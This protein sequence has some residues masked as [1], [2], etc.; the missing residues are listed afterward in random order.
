MS[1]Y[2][3]KKSVSSEGREA[4]PGPSHSVAGK[5][6]LVEGIEA[7]PVQR[8]ATGEP[9]KAAEP[10]ADT[11]TVHTAVAQAP[12]IAA[13]TAGIDK[14]GFIDNSDGAKIRTGPVEAGGKTVRDQPLPP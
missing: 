14:P 2:D 5:H 9:A 12:E 11:A 10:A 4:K 1:F 8:R 3:R 7:T 13:P 6:T